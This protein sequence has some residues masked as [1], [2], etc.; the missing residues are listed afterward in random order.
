MNAYEMRFKKLL[1][2]AYKFYLCLLM[3]ITKIF[4]ENIGVIAN[5]QFNNKQD[6][7]IRW[8][9]TQFNLIGSE[10]YQTRVDIVQINFPNET[11]QIRI[12]YL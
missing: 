7:E 12:Q 8:I 9:N 2:M 10:I 4:V 6:W 11:S 5:D 3:W 1:I